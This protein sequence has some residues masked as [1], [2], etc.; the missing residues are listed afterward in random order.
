MDV[1]RLQLLAILVTAGPVRARVR[2]RAP[3]PAAGALR[4][5]VAVRLRDPARP[6]RSGAG[7]SRTLASAVGIFYAPSAL[8]AVAFGFVLVLLLHFSLVIS[9]LAE[10]TKVLAQRVGHAA[11]RGRRAARPPRRRRGGRGGASRSSSPRAVDGGSRVVVVTHDC[12][13]RCWARRW[14]ARAPQLRDGDELVVVDC[15]SSDDP[16]VAV[17]GAR[18]RLVALE[19]EPRLRR[20]RRDAGAQE[21][22]APLLFFLNPDARAR[23]RLPRRAARAPRRTPDWG[24]WQALVMLPGGAA[25]Q[26]A[27]RRRALARLRLGGRVRRAGRERRPG[28]PARSAS[29]PAPRWSCGATRGTRSAASTPPTSCTARTSTSRC[30]CGS[31]AGAS[32]SCPAA[33][34]EHDYEFDKGDYKWFHLERNRWWTVLGTYPARAARAARA[35]AAR[36]SSSR[37]SRSRRRGGWLR[38]KLRA[39]LRG[40]ARRCR[41]AAPAARVQAP[42]AATAGGVRRP[43]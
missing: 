12:D 33:R 39:Q 28:E 21:T 18:A 34:V 24:A 26:H 36:P 42:R 25:R 19:R 13:A 10:Q 16:A 6:R 41:G 35:G 31:P 9:R 4:A 8:F 23:A 17:A 1:S 29:P 22:A 7:C 5:A 32:A 43:A 37:C 38:A 3:A 30:G 20:R 40:A 11:A 27:R 2:A 14:R 15:A